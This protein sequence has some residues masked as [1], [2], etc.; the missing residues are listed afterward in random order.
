MTA[1]HAKARYDDPPKTV[2][3]YPRQFDPFREA[4]GFD[5]S[6]NDA[7]KLVEF[8]EQALVLTSGPQAG[9]PFRPQSWQCDWLATLNG[10]RDPQGNRRF[11]EGLFA[12]PRKQGKTEI[13]AGVAIFTL[14][15]DGE[16]RAQV[17]SAAKT[18]QQASMVY[19]PASIMCR[20]SP[21]LARR[22][23]VTPSRKR[24]DFAPS[25][26]W[27]SALSSDAGAAHGLSPHCVLFDELHNQT[28]RDLY[29]ALKSG[30]GARPNRMFLSLTTAGHGR[31]TICR[32]VWTAAQRVRD[33]AANLPR[34]LPLIYESPDG[35][36]WESE[37]LWRA[38][39]PNLG[40]TVG[41]DFYQEEWRK[42]KE[43]PAY[44]N[45]FRNLY[46]NQ[47]TEQAVRWLPMDRWDL[48]G[49]PID[50]AELRGRWCWAAIDLSATTDLSCFVMA[51]PLD[52]GRVAIVPRFWRPEGTTDAAAKRDHVD[53]REW[54]RRGYMTLQPGSVVDQAAIRA[55]ILALREQYEIREIAIDPWN[56]AWLCTQLQA[57]GLEVV[58]HRQGYASMSAPSK[59]FEALVLGGKLAHN[60]H[61]V[62]RMC[63]ANVAIDTDPAGN[64]KPTKASSSGRIDGI[65]AAIMA[66]GRANT[67]EQ[68][69]S[70]FFITG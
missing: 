3:G 56:A 20:T 54:G 29:D 24:I 22:F 21:M 43:S 30:Q 61:P 63:A 15:C 13:G 39:N 47:W 1:V 70:P 9:K 50:E 7:R 18:Q 38:V 53:Y 46:L 66:T 37:D 41:L 69:C 36:D 44:E 26:S 6:P 59:A 27:Y 52:D 12:T 23:S 51:F 40:V 10:W 49:D 48:C 4:D 42:A 68:T 16:A 11:R 45:T 55:E 17:Y 34:F 8:F 19:E 14:G 67:A 60:G 62:M 35:A 5:W 57:D 65:V 2:P 31:E 64:I 32:E 33:G 28:S 25:S 58:E